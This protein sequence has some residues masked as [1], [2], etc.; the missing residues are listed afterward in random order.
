[1]N[2]LFFS[3]KK[4]N[5]MNPIFIDEYPKNKNRNLKLPVDQIIN[6]DVIVLEE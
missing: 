1:M 5:K 2:F 6:G 4:V 3:I